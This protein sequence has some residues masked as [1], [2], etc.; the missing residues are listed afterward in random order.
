MLS[1]TLAPLPC[2]KP[3]SMAFSLN[4]SIS[5]SICF[6]VK[7]MSMA[8]SSGSGVNMHTQMREPFWLVPKGLSAAG[9]SRSTFRRICSSRPCAA[10]C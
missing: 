4:A 2:L 5:S 6:E 8:T 7:A 1:T 10:A 3:T 9:P